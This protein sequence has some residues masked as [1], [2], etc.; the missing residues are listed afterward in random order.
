MNRVF[1]FLIF[2][3]YSCA[4]SYHPEL[5]SGIQ[6]NY[7]SYIP[8][9]T[10]VLKCRSWPHTV[11]IA[12]LCASVDAHI[13]DNFRGQNFMRGL[14]PRAVD[15][16]LAE[17]KKE[18]LLSTLLS[19]WNLHKDTPNIAEFYDEHV[20]KKK[21]W[22]SWLDDFSVHTH[23]TDA[24]LIPFLY[25]AKEEKENDRG[26]LHSKRSLSLI[27]LLIDTQSGDLIW[28]SQ[29]QRTLKNST[30]GNEY[31]LFPEWNLLLQD[32]LINSLWKDYPGKIFLSFMQSTCSDCKNRFEKVL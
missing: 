24:L 32:L 12:T 21:E 8:A 22:L 17:A 7:R 27:L 29:R 9:R 20:Q 16:A 14:S 3:S 26:L 10:A 28:T 31:T 5:L 25:L 30:F 11:D 6:T 15:K 2:I 23:H 4:S 19:T 13:L 1:F 18:P